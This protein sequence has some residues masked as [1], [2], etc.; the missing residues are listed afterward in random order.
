M[1]ASAKVSL[2]T[3]LGLVLPL[4]N[5]WGPFLIKVGHDRYAYRLRRRLLVIEVLLTVVCF[6]V[7]I[8]TL[9]KG[10]SPTTVDTSYITQGIY[11]LLAMNILVIVVAIISLIVA[12]RHHD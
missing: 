3:L 6:V 7:S 10:F 5:I 4:G 12:I 11:P 1:N 2:L 9:V 8:A